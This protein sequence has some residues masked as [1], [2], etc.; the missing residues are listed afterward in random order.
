MAKK[1][2]KSVK[3]LGK[4][5]PPAKGPASQGFEGFKKFA[6]GGLVSNKQKKNKKC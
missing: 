2:T 4:G 3:K 6:T 1:K 5:T